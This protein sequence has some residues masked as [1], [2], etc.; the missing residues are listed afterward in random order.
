MSALNPDDHEN[1]PRDIPSEE[2]V[3]G[4]CL[5]SQYAI[6]AAAEFGLTTEDFYRPAHQMIYEAARHLADSGNPVSVASVNAELV[7]RGQSTVT[8]GAVK[9][10]ELSSDTLAPRQVTYYANLVMEQASL[11]LAL[12]G[13]RTSAHAAFNGR[14]EVADTIDFIAATMEKATAPR[15]TASDGFV[16]L[17]EVMPAVIDRLEKPDGERDRVEL[18]YLDLD[19]LTGGI[20]PGEVL[21]VAGRPGMGKTTLA[22]DAARHAALRRGNPVAFFSL[23]MSSEELAT[24]I[25]CAESRV[26]F[27]AMNNG[28]MNDADWDR[29]RDATQRMADSPLMIDDAPNTTTAHIRAR[30]RGMARTN[31]ARLVVVDYLQLMKAPGRADSRQQEVADISRELKLIAKEFGV[32][33]ILVAQLNRGPEQRADKRPMVS[34]LRESGAVEQDADMVILLFR[35]DAYEKESPRAGEADLIVAKHRGGPTADVTVAFH[36]H[37]CRLTDMAQG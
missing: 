37:L 28:L 6:E 2:T 18:P 36:G 3:L 25:L 4:L 13:A 15:K 33:L 12:K 8:G 10:I 23:E 5:V 16:S 27:H 22:Q 32:G 9:L 11:R 20:E 31:P 14:G 26:P 30:L 21:V 7:K 19:A 35:E 24:R 29:V 1:D 17:G 34:D